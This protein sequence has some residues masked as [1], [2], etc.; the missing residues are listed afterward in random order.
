MA[1]RQPEVTRSA[2]SGRVFAA[3][4]EEPA[5]AEERHV[6]AVQVG[7]WIMPIHMLVLKKLKDFD[8]ILGIDWLSKYY[9]SIDCKSKLKIKSEDVQKTTFRT[10]YGHYEFTVM[11]FGL[12]N[13]PAA[14][15]DLM[16]HVFKAYLDRFVV[17]FIDGILIYSRSD[18]EHAE[19]LRANVVADALSRKSAENLALWVTNQVPLWKEMGQMDLEVVAPE[20]TTMLST[21]V[22]QP[23]LLDRIK[24]L[25]PADLNLQKVQRDIEGGCGGDFSINAGGVL[26]YG[27]RWCVLEGEDVRKLI[28][29]SALVSL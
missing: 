10:Q 8:V 2:P 5:E 7:N 15:M 22:V 21:L 25:Q 23:T 28:A 6:V 12:I 9:A 18:E 17:V 27:N 20:V 11:P 14:F 29:R 26:R 13:A 16:N 3:Q 4:V 19:H 24:S 1:P